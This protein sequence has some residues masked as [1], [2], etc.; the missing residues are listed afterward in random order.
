[1]KLKHRHIIGICFLCSLLGFISC[2]NDPVDLSCEE[3]EN[4]IYLTF[5]T[6]VAGVSTRADGTDGKSDELIKQ[7]LVVIVSEEANSSVVTE[8]QVEGD[9]T[10]GMKWMLEHSRLVKGTSDI[11]LQLTNEYTFKVKAGCRKRIYLLANCEGLRGS[12]GKLLDFTGSSFLPRVDG[13]TP[14]DNF[15]FSL[16]AAGVNSSGAKADSYNYNP[17][18]YGIPM[19]ALYEIDIPDRETL[20]KS[21]E[22]QLPEPLYVVRAATKFSFCFMKKTAKRNIDVMGF[23]LEEIIRDRMY[24][25][26]HVNKDKETG[27]YWIVD[28]S[29]GFSKRFLGEESQSDYTDKDWIK[30]MNQEAE[31]CEDENEYLEK[32]QWLTDY[33][34]PL[35]L[36]EEVFD[37]EEAFHVVDFSSP[38]E[39]PL[40]KEDADSKPA[41]SLRTVYL[42]ESCNRKSVS[43]GKNSGLFAD[44]K[45]QEYE[46]TI[47]TKEEFSNSSG[48]ETGGIGVKGTEDDKEKVDRKYTARL[49]YLA[50][51]FRNT[52]V[53]VNI[54]FNDYTIDWTVDVEP[55]WAV[56][57]EPVFGL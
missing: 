43:E 10:S 2:I 13:T 35:P 23:R 45:L 49:P 28:S 52:H 36:Q 18:L 6:D 5:R 54:V 46:L 16:G 24:L 34:V 41:E 20:G 22:Y 9:A 1:M 30:W 26:P 32:Y 4:S 12:D 3:E 47:Y 27:Q 21:D 56:D 31:K 14:I 7:L 42:P 11:G 44:L 25:M 50:S 39:V 17:D 29:N 51:L 37:G 53:K 19:T 48:K 8:E 33:E 15:V 57:L 38:V 40:V 55:Y